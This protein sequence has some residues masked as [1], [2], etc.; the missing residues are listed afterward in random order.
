MPYD[1]EVELAHYLWRNLAGLFSERER[2]IERAL[3]MR[4]WAVA[5]NNPRIAERL[6][7]R[8]A[9]QGSPEI[10]AA[11]A[12]GLDAFRRAACRRVLAERG[13]QIIVNRCPRCTR[14][15]RTPKAMQCFW[16]GHDWHGNA[17]DPHPL[18]G[19]GAS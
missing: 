15:V 17:S 1:D 13:D 19:S 10:D 9:G 6:A 5:T 16:C 14:V 11:V 8:W 3:Q 12:R 7:E 4:E 18:I 2:Q